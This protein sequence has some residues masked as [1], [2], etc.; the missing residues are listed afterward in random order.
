MI[1]SDLREIKLLLEIDPNNHIS[2][3]VLQLY[4]EWATS[5]IEEFCGGRR[6]TYRARTEYY[7]GTGCQK[8]VLRSRPVFPP[9]TSVIYDQ[10]G[11]YG[12]ASGAFTNP[13]NTPLVYGVDY[14]LKID[15]DDGTSR[16]A[17]L[18]N[19][20]SY[21]QRPTVRQMGLLTPFQGPDTG[22]Y[23]VIYN[24]GYTVDTL[25]G[26]FRA[27]AGL[28]VVRLNN[29]FPIGQ[30]IGNE[31]Y[32]ERSIGYIEERKDYL[33]ALVKPLLFSYRNFHW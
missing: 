30:A 24:A 5:I 23:Q 15:E 9:I 19:I 32:E 26:A 4:N 21:W 25:P 20:N 31:S 28:L 16:S 18:Y 7:D 6:F 8:L 29:L 13:P 10:G 11:L 27:A 12:Q 17:I 1:F 2:D 22:S 14:T 3:N 33:L